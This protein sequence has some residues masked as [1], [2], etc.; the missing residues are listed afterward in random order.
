MRAPR[1]SPHTLARHSF[2]PPPTLYSTTSEQRTAMP[3]FSRIV[4]VGVVFIA[5]MLSVAQLYTTFA[6]Q[7]ALASV[8]S[9]SEARLDTMKRVAAAKAAVCSDVGGVWVSGSCTVKPTHT[10][11]TEVAAVA[12]AKAAV[13]SDVGGVW[14]SGS[15]TITPTHTTATK[16]VAVDAA[17]TQLAKELPQ[18][19]A[20][21]LLA[22]PERPSAAPTTAT[23][24]T[25]APVTT[26]APTTAAPATTATPATTA[27]PTTATPSVEGLLPSAVVRNL[28]GSSTHGAGTTSTTTASTATDAPIA[29]AATTAAATDNAGTISTTTASTATATATDAPID[30]NAAIAAA[31]A[32]SFVEEGKTVQGG[33]RR[34]TRAASAT[35]RYRVPD[36]KYGLPMPKHGAPLTLDTDTLEPTGVACKMPFTHEGTEYHTCKDY[37]QGTWCET[38]DSKEDSFK[39]GYCTHSDKPAFGDTYDRKRPYYTVTMSRDQG[40]WGKPCK[41][42]EN[43]GCNDF[44]HEGTY[45]GK[46]CL[47]HFDAK[48]KGKESEQKWGWCSKPNVPGWDKMQDATNPPPPSETTDAPGTASTVVS[49]ADTAAAALNKDGL[50]LTYTLPVDMPIGQYDLRLKGGRLPPSKMEFVVS[51]I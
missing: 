25:A 34:L 24:T 15:C 35:P 11:A 19:H 36:P 50:R 40:K 46:W 28:P 4:G 29:T 3:T 41:E 7:G 8:G 2:L 33:G 23:P 1:I 20:P 44:N 17:N 5:V 12:A 39:W 51:L 22:I 13:C 38:L 6:G 45:Q 30:P 48:D 32:T 18:H 21:R 27:A 9:D 43:R 31:T 49:T 26:A 14:A 37:K 42:P 16:A 10:T 47:I